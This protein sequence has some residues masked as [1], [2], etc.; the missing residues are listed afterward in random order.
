MKVLLDTNIIIHRER[1]D[2]VEEEIGKLFWWIDKLDYKKYIHQKT[3]EEIQRI[4]D[5]KRL[6]AF[7][8]KMESYNILPTE[9]DICRDIQDIIDTMD[10]NDN[11]VV[12][13]ILLNEVMC[14]RVDFLITEDRKIH[15]KAEILNIDEKVFTI[16][17][18]LEKATSENPEL[19]DYEILSIQK[20]FF[21]NINIKDEFF[22]CFR[23]DYNG[24]EKWFASKSDETAYF[25]SIDDKIVAFL[26]LKIE[27]KDEPYNDIEPVFSRKKRFKIGTFKVT[28][29]GFKLGERFLKILFDNALNQKVEEIYVTIFPKRIEQQR[30]ISLLLEYGFRYHGVKRSQSGEEEVYVRDF[31]PMV[32]LEDP[33]STFPYLSGNANH[34]IVSIY[35][36]YHTDLF[37]DSILRN[38]SPLD[39]I[40]NEPFRN[41]ISKVFISRSIN[42]NLKS[43]DVIVFY[44]TGGYYRSVVTTLG[45]VESVHTNIK[46]FHHFV[47]ICRKRTVFSD[48]ELKLHWDYRPNNRPFVVNFLYAYSFPRRV[49][50][51]K[52]IELGI[53]KD[54][55][56]APR[57]FE[58]ITKDD[59]D[60][61][62]RETETNESIVV[63]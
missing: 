18:F 51:Q 29:N 46:D 1:F 24:F 48:E 54:I 43:G 63:N 40:E 19:L 59:F 28:L 38:E 36:Q 52:L 60:N 6:E 17:G 23:E 20:D 12:D 62:I 2:P 26:Y 58:P 3:I 53:I 56:S 35:P 30:L 9:A 8:I 22:D 55:T 13:S 41:A 32:S 39:F 25:S 27:G 57:G 47:N 7:T 44:R 37:P 50:M 21:G 34:H 4:Q 49:N 15:K 16:D 45:I 42:K 33:K 61:I 10:K 5:A 11:D 31:K 14:G